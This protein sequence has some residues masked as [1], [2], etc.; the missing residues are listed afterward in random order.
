MTNATSLTTHDLRFPT[1]S[2]LDGWDAMNSDPGY[3]AA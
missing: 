1:F 3:S 2:S